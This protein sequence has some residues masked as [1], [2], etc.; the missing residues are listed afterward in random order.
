MSQ[1][2]K[3]EIQ[4]SSPTNSNSQTVSTTTLNPNS[5]PKVEP[6][7]IMKEFPKKTGKNTIILIVVSLFIV[8]AGIGTGWLLSGGASGS[9]GSKVEDST[10]TEMVDSE[11]EA[12]IADESLFEEESPEGL[13]VEG[14]I[15]GEGTHHLERDGGPSKYVYLTSTL[16]NLQDF[17]GKKVKVWGDTLSGKSAGWLM[18][19]GKIKEID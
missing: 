2:V 8:L 9:G 10:V 14:G 6:K 13:L 1:I 7:K 18:D 4:S 11:S 12:G 17:V 5:S 16:I 15:N 3:S 19:V